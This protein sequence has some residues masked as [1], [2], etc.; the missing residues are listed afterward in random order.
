MKKRTSIRSRTALLLGLALAGAGVAMAEDI[1][2]QVQAV[3]IR[4][5]KGS[6]YPPVAQAANQQRLEIVAREPEGWLKVKI[7]GKEG[8]V[9]ES[10]L[11]PRSPSMF[12]GA[13][14]GVNALTGNNPDV[15]ASAAARGIKD[16]AA[17]YA[18]S[19]G[20]NTAAL[21]QMIANRD[22]VAGERWVQFAQEGKVGPSKP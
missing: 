20:Y 7:A 16:D 12:G 18:S 9:K 4:S 3:A 17:K 10:A 13:S 8:Y 6:M 11:K 21:D 2:V 5:G 1:V 19:K 22:R 15:G 14:S